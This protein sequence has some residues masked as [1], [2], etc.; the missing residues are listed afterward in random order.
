MTS[1]TRAGGLLR[2]A[3]LATATLAAVGLGHG[4]ATRAPTET[5][6]KAAF[7][8]HFAQLVTWP[9][10]PGADPA[11][12]IVIAVLGR[13]PFGER[14]EATI[15]R[16]TA[17]GRPLRIERFAKTSEIVAPPQI[18]F[19]GASDLA[20][21]RAMLA[22]V[23]D[24]PVLTVAALPGFAHA[25]GMVEFRITPDSRVAF[26]INLRAVERAGLSMSS[27]LLKIARVVEPAP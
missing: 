12:P 19:V 27:Q 16:E 14:L 8:Y 25:G 17:R 7:L 20:Q 11:A 3:G 5:E 9:E 23:K 15:G 1:R 6:V 26:D 21:A 10:A 22:A 4:A 24:G 2:R 13:D 18:L